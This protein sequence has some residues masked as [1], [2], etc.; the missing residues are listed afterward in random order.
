[1][2]NSRR[3]FLRGAFLQRQSRAPL[4]PAPPWHQ[5]KLSTEQCRD[6]DAPCVSACPS[7]IIKQHPADHLLA[8]TPYLDFSENGCTYCGECAKV[9]PMELDSNSP[10]PKLG[11]ILL[12]QNTCLSWNKVFCISCRNQCEAQA[13]SIDSQMRIQL[14]SS[15]CT[16]C[17]Q[18]IPACPNQSLSIHT[19]DRTADKNV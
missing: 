1:M 13:L 14:D 5:H 19:T 16:A 3:A 7:N 10:A 18:C 8:A 15:A 17:G 11:H 4:G 6:C 12:D 2:D 9:C